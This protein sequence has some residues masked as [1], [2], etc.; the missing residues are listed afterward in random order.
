MRQ[1][2][3]QSM[4]D[5]YDEYV[6]YYND[7]GKEKADHIPI[8]SELSAIEKKAKERANKI[9]EILNESSVEAEES[10]GKVIKEKAD[11]TKDQ[12]IELKKL[13]DRI[14]HSIDWHIQH[15]DYF[16]NR[17]VEHNNLKGK[18]EEFYEIAGLDD[19]V[20]M[21]AFLFE[22]FTMILPKL[23]GA[24]N[25]GNALWFLTGKIIDGNYPSQLDPYK[26]LDENE[27]REIEEEQGYVPYHNTREGLVK[28]LKK[29]I[30]EVQSKPR[31]F[32]D[33]G[34]IKH[35]T[36]AKHAVSKD[37]FADKHGDGHEGLHKHIKGIFKSMNST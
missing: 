16:S 32:H 26:D 24:A 18:I 9:R 33:D 22:I 30:K 21:A 15:P 35:T 25:H 28:D 34:D 1:S 17:E 4:E 31:F 5:I 14:M 6:K 3:N 12:I 20:S 27:K 13:K 29:I 19:Q 8:L 7:A 10:L 37:W 2:D 23:K 36:V 11:C